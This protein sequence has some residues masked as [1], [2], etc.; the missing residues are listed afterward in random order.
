MATMITH[1]GETPKSQINKAETTGIQQF[2]QFILADLAMRNTGAAI[3]ATT[4]GRS[5]IKMRSTIILSRK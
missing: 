2:F 3:S 1:T 5:P 4:A